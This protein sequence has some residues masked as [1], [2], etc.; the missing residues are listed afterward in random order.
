MALT[1]RSETIHKAVWPDSAVQQIYD[2]NCISPG[3]QLRLYYIEKTD[4]RNMRIVLTRHS[5]SMLLLVIMLQLVY[6]VYAC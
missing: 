4:G 5:L 2:W 6:A 3:L 1:A